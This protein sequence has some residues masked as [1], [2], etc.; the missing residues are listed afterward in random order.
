LIILLLSLRIHSIKEEIYFFPTF[1]KKKFEKRLLFFLI[2]TRPEM[3]KI[4]P[5]LIELKKQN[6]F[7]T[8]ICLSGQHQNEMLN[9]IITLFNIEIDC[10]LNIEKYETNSEFLSFG[11]QRMNQLYKII[12]PKFIFVQG[13]TSSL[14]FLI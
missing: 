8:L 4:A 6:K 2:G 7:S 1:E 12:Q 13:D 11:L 9:P 3:I 5:I 14:N 10:H